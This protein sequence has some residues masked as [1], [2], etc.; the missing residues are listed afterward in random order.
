M[1]VLGYKS[2]YARVGFSFLISHHDKAL[3]YLI[4]A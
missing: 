1:H 2:F 3:K 4:L